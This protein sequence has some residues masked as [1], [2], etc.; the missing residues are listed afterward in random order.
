MTDITDDKV[1]NARQQKALSALLVSPTIRKAA[2]V[3]GVPEDTI[4]R[5]KRK[6]AAFKAAYRAATLEIARETNSDVFR[7]TPQLWQRLLYLSSNA[8]S[9]A[10]QLGATLGGLNLIYKLCELE[11]VV[12]RLEALEERYA[13]KL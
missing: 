7:A 2:E 13:T 5:W 8:R 9:E 11:D 10:V 6:D 3:S 12:R 4:S 1:L